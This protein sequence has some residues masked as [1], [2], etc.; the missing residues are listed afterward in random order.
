MSMKIARGMAMVL[1][2]CCLT[3]VSVLWWWQR[4]EH[5]VAE[6]DMA[7]Y[8]VLL[9]VVLLLLVVALRRVWQGADARASALHAPLVVAQA[10]AQDPRGQAT[11]AQAERY[12]TARLVHTAILS[13]GGAQASDLVQAVADGQPAPSPDKV[14]VGAAGLPAM[15]ARLPD[16]AL[17]LERCQDL[18][19]ALADGMR[20][21]DERWQS[22]P[23]SEGCLR[24]LA[25]LH[26]PLL[27]QRQWLLE[28]AMSRSNSHQPSP[29]PIVRL[30]LG[31]A[32][33]WTAFEHRLAQ[34][35]VQLRW[36]GDDDAME[37]LYDLHLQL[38]PG[39][40]ETLWL[41]ADQ[42]AHGS[43]AQSTPAWLLLAA[44]HSDVDQA[45]VDALAAAGRL[46]DHRN[47]PGGAMPG[48]A[49]ATLLF[50][51]SD[52]QAPP[53]LTVRP[54]L[55]HR[56]ALTQ[57]NKPVEACGKVDAQCLRE[58]LTQALRA[59]QLQAA[60]VASV[61]C[62]ADQ[63][64]Q[65]ATELYSVTIAD[66]PQLDPLDDMRVLGKVTGTAGAASALLVVACAAEMARTS[67][68]P[69][70]ALGMADSHLRLALIVKPDLSQ[71]AAGQASATANRTS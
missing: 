47:A 2:V 28:Q 50:A 49:A 62:D 67:Q 13:C 21:G 45:R 15:C 41:Q 63:H 54:V 30:L 51:P 10:N 9:P 17:A 65:R 33:Q 31:C 58:A 69:V 4:T 25:A 23:V 6:I 27:S 1:A 61:V 57:R 60:Q 26:E 53:D 35:W 7:V 12:A 11:E 36:A 37:T 14:L 40:G 32:A 16:A 8:L 70:L 59:A 29:R 5:A 42:S 34:R 39:A 24:A 46:Y 48:E 22:E 55:V 66:L 18:I 43:H 52:W 44:A 19:E 68:Q 56:P 64:S 38:V 71:D 3:W 20:Q